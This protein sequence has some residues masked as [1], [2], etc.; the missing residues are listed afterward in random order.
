MPESLTFNCVWIFLH[1][2][3]ASAITIVCILNK[4]NK[5]THQPSS[6]KNTLVFQ[7]LAFIKWCWIQPQKLPIICIWKVLQCVIYLFF[8]KFSRHLM[9]IFQFHN[10]Q[11][12][13]TL[14][15]L[16]TLKS[17]ISVSFHSLSQLYDALNYNSTISLIVMRKHVSALAIVGEEKLF[18]ILLSASM[19]FTHSRELKLH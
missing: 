5:F 14:S 16:F 19:S 12:Y 8:Q 6:I 15:K 7:S 10:H 1:F 3:Y 9:Q 11:T 13:P 4:F 17:A 18:Q 2:Q